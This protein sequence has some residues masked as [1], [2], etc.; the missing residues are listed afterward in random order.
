ML[1]TFIGLNEIKPFKIMIAR[2]PDIGYRA[3]IKEYIFRIYV[4]GHIR[5]NGSSR[6]RPGKY[7]NS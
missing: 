6:E 5:G 4:P 1:N 3:I 7:P 2:L